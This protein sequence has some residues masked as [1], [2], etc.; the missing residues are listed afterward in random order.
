MVPGK[1][2]PILNTI[3]GCGIAVIENPSGNAERVAQPRSDISYFISSDLSLGIDGHPCRHVA[4]KSSRTFTQQP[5]E[6]EPETE[7]EARRSKIIK[8]L[9]PKP[10][11][12]DERVLECHISAASV[13]GSMLELEFSG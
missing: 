4:P 10:T 3:D 1:F 5:V 11:G 12:V 7:P 2:D 6:I 13:Q 8:S 9:S